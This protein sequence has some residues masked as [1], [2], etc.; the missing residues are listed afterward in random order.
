MVVV[1][2]GPGYDVIGDVHGCASTLERLLDTLGYAHDGHSWRHRERVAVFVGDLVDRGPQQIEAVRI[3]H[4][5]HRRGAAHVVMGN[6]EFNAIAY[7]TP[8]PLHPG[9]HLRTHSDRHTKQHRSFLEAVGFGT[10]L[11]TEIIDWFRTLPLW[12]ERDG[13]RVVHACWHDESMR[14]LGEAVLTPDR[15]EAASRRGSPAWRSVETLCKGPE[16]ELPAGIT[17]T[18]KDGH[19]RREARLR[20]WDPGADTYAS[21]CEVPPSC[22]ELPDT[23][24]P[25][26]AVHGYHGEQPVVFGHY[27]RRE[28]EVRP[29]TVCVDLSVAKG[30]PL[31][32]YRWSGEP[33]LLS[34]NTIAVPS[35]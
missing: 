20:W 19:E 15:H 26:D 29:L 22:G 23:P 8:D 11:H 30:G 31:A 5:M 25:A 13:L 17:F 16:I 4:D 32:A 1:I 35:T 28:F 14:T 27:W 18:D 3:A 2:A 12:W 9:E 21:A 34:S 7:A 6:H 33:T 24:L 10:A